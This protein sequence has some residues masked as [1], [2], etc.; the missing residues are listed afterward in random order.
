DPKLRLVAQYADDETGLFYH[1][2]RY[3]DPAQGRF[4]S[5]DPA[6]IA[7][8]LNNPEALRL[9]LTAY[10]GGLP[11][12]Y[13]DPD[14]AAKLQYLLI[15]AYGGAPTNP[16]KS[17]LA[18]GV[19]PRMIH[20]AFYLTDIAAAPGEHLLY[21]P[22]GTFSGLNDEGALAWS[23]GTGEWNR[24]QSH[25]GKSISTGAWAVIGDFDDTVALELYKALSGRDPLNGK[26]VANCDAKAA[27]AYLPD[28]PE[29]FYAFEHYAFPTYIHLLTQPIFFAN[30]MPDPNDVRYVDASV[31][32]WGD[33]TFDAEGND[34]ADDRFYSRKPHLP[35]NNEGDVIGNSGTTLGRGYDFGGKKAQDVKN[36][37][38][39]LNMSQANIDL[40]AGAIGKQGNAAAPY[41]ENNVEPAGIELTREQQYLLFLQSYKDTYNDAKRAYDN[42][43]PKDVG[44]TWDQLDPAIRDVIVDMRFRGDF[45]NL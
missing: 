43:F 3:Y 45:K 10:A 22:N 29:G 18:T 5:P 17:T 6:G 26:P 19:D 32:P 23:G 34:A 37:L 7:D 40:L 33:L 15:D 20:F 41:F 42:N 27:L 36:I 24:F 9:D 16:S 44:T 21:D 13:V 2:A 31:I 11:R 38:F 25:Y 8:S 35:Q 14:G 28:L 1:L 12:F 30:E 4:I 39:R